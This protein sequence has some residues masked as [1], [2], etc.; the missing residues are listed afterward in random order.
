MKQL[1]RIILIALITSFYWTNAH[2]VIK[3]VCAENVYGGIAKTLGGPHVSVISILNNPNQDPHLFTTRPSDAIAVSKADILIYNG[4]N[5]DPWMHSLLS[6]RGK[7]PPSVIVVADLMHLQADADPH[8]WYNPATIPRLAAHLNQ[9]LQE[10]DPSHQQDYA[11]NY[12]QLMKEYQKLTITLNQCKQQ[13]HGTPVIATEPLFNYMADAIGL[14]MQG[15]DFQNSIMNDLPPT[16]SQIKRFQ[17]ALRQR[18]VRALIYNKQVSNPLTHR[19]IDIANAAS[20][21][22]IGMSETQPQD[23]DYVQWMV[24]QL[25][26]LQTAL[27]PRQDVKHD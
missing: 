22:I 8:I 20:I 23:L 24:S 15:T 27:T 26:A 6:V 16:I 17:D 13:F 19:I 1:I 5:Y 12:Q 11:A 21:P 9:L 25:K 18:T 7:K 2:A 10:K 14:K 3:I 4:A